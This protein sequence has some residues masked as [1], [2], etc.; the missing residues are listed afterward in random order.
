MIDLNVSAPGDVRALRARDDRLRNP[1]EL[2]RVLR[3]YRSRA[4][5]ALIG[6]RTPAMS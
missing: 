3:E 5:A 4:P 6:S 2:G 1:A